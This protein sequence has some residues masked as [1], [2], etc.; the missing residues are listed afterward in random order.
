MPS[1]Y[2]LLRFLNVFQTVCSKSL[3]FLKGLKGRK[4]SCRVKQVQFNKEDI[5]VPFSYF[6]TLFTTRVQ[7]FVKP[8]CIIEFVSELC[9]PVASED[10]TKGNV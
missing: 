5:E 7:E 3:T 10:E 6:L 9:C 4:D 8:L 2:M 1:H